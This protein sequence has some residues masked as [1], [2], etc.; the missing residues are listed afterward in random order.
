MQNEFQSGQKIFN[1]YIDGFNLYKGALEDRPDLKW[2][3]LKGLCKSLMPGQELKKIYYFT[4]PLMNRYEGDRANERQNRYLR[5]LTQS[6]VEVVKG[7]FRR[8]QVWERMT[9]RVHQEVIEPNL[10]ENDGITQSA[11]DH[12]WESTSPD[13]P[14]AR[15]LKFEEKGSDV[16]IACYLLRDAYLGVTDNALLISGDSDLVRA[17]D[18]ARN[19]GVVVKVAVPSKTRSHANL[20]S[21]ADYFTE[22]HTKQLRENQFPKTFVG[23]N[24]RQII[25]PAEWT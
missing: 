15:V 12:I 8:D 14:K 2:L 19:T 9:S 16:N 25:R 11:F 7:N 17:V 1:A 4:A 23:A 10:P 6:G 20:K 5:A 13:A 18:F 3:D 22:I 24:G 21:S